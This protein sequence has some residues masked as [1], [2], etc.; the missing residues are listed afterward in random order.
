VPKSHILHSGLVLSGLAGDFP[1]E[2]DNFSLL[3]LMIEYGYGWADIN[4][5]EV[6]LLMQLLDNR[7]SFHKYSNVRIHEWGIQY[8]PG[9]RI[10]MIR[11]VHHQHGD[12]W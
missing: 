10:I 3:I 9:E 5:I 6:L 7:S 12:L 4:S 8:V 1:M 2:R 11:V